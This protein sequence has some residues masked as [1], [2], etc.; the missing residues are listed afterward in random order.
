M[1]NYR[2]PWIFIY[3]LGYLYI[4]VDIY[5]ISMIFIYIYVDIYYKSVDIHIY[6]WIFIYICGYLLYINLNSLLL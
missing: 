5:N 4:S 3:I 1:D 2:Y 6:P